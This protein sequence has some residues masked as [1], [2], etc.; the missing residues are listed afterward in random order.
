MVVVVLGV[1]PLMLSP[2]VAP[3]R[4]HE[5]SLSNRSNSRG[6]PAAEGGGE[7]AG[8]ELLPRDSELA[9][10]AAGGAGESG[11]GGEGGESG[12][13]YS[14][15]PH[16][17]ASDAPFKAPDGGAGDGGRGRGGSKT[18]AQAERQR[19]GPGAAPRPRLLSS[20]TTVGIVVAATLASFVLT[21]LGE[22][23]VFNGALS[24]IM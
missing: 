4:A 15:L 23:N 14:E 24:V 12:C 22:I 13:P 7:G 18:Q 17:D 8:M 11:E 19:Q 6:G 2:M 16:R 21:D 1:F 9:R 20:L 3:V 10:E 5:D